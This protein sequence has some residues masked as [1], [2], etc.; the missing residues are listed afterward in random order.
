MATPVT[1]TNPYIPPTKTGALNPQGLT[2]KEMSQYASQLSQQAKG[3]RRQ[4]EIDAAT[5]LRPKGTVFDPATNTFK[6]PLMGTTYI[7]AATGELT[8]T[9]EEVLSAK[10]GATEGLRFQLAPKSPVVVSTSQ[11]ALD[12][13]AAKR[14]ETDKLLASMQAQ[15]D[16]RKSLEQA[17]PAPVTAD[18]IA[19]RLTMQFGAPETK[20]V[21]ADGQAFTVKKT[22]ASELESLNKQADDAFAKYQSDIDSL[23]TGTFPLTPTQQAQVNSIRTSTQR[24]IDAQ[25][26]AN[27]NYVGATRIAGMTSGR[28]RYAPELAAQELQSA[29]SAG[30]AK[31]NDIE[32]KAQE[33]I[34]SL[35]AAF[36][37]RNYRMI[38]AQYTALQGYLKQKTD[39]IQSMQ[40]LV[41][42][43]ELKM[44]EMKQKAENDRILNTIKLAEFDSKQKEIA[45]NQMIKSAE[46][47]QEEKNEARRFM[48]DSSKFSWEQKMDMMK[49]TGMDDKGN[50]TLDAQKT[51][52]E[53][54]KLKNADNPTSYKEWKLAGSPGTYSEFL[55]KSKIDA[56]PPTQDQSQAGMLVMNAKPANDIIKT[57]TDSYAKNLSVGDF[58]LQK[59]L[60][61]FAKSQEFRRFEQAS[62]AFVEAWLRKT[63]GAAISEG[64][65]RNGFAQFLPTAGDGPVVLAQK[66]RAR[67]NVIQGLTNAAGPAVSEE[68]RQKINIPTYFTLDDYAVGNPETT[69]RGERKNTLEVIDLI[70]REQPQLSDDDI[71]QLL[72]TSN[73][74]T[75]NN[76]GGDT[77]EA[78]SID[79][80]VESIG[81]YES[82]SNY[83]ALGPVIP[84]G[85]YEGDRAYGKYQV[86]GK[87]V[88]SWTKMAL[89]REL[90]PQQFLK[91]PQAQDA[92]ARYMLGKYVEEH[93]TPEDAA[94]VWFSGRP[95]ANNARKDLATGVSVP[96]YVRNVMG[97]YNA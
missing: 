4:A 81:K 25:K 73:L 60:P 79:K 17:T 11:A 22:D 18:D 58:L 37:D 47:T 77:N 44:M 56:K 74:Q 36:E 14:S 63:S 57:M 54:E 50:L 45:F 19:S 97:F 61:D 68:F 62:R 65:W 10:P 96:Q 80:L 5:K 59:N 93:G 39:T 52:A 84:S 75:F 94:S 87:N 90:T 86:M 27:A 70:G 88:P 89:G 72:Q 83:A 67:A 26:V 55:T 21:S 23:K 95:L 2:A 30:I 53:I 46:F 12:D 42:D 28:S 92:V 82:G 9:G 64:E 20:D 3:E 8:P 1:N 78:V 49:M 76:V 41:Q 16:L 29:V 32:N 38:N 6:D 51:I 31:I 24:M 7:G 71:L 43:R 13:L 15:S 85:M 40:K 35:Q 91:N 34:A 66:E 48:L 33:S 69:F